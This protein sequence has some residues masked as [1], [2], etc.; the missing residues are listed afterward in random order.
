MNGVNFKYLK[1]LDFLSSTHQGIC[2]FP[3]Q[4]NFDIT[5]VFLLIILHICIIKDPTKPKTQRFSTTFS[6]SKHIFDVSF[7]D[8]KQI[9]YAI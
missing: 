5:S 7:V 6:F 2:D 9:S 3:Y 4:F 8:T 1:N